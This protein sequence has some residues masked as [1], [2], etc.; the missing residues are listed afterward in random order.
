MCRGADRWG[1]SPIHPVMSHLHPSTGVEWGELSRP[2]HTHSMMIPLM[3]AL[4]T[5][6]GTPDVAATTA[7]EGRLGVWES[8]RAL[9]WHDVSASTCHCTPKCL[10]LDQCFASHGS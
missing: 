2:A 7:T 8:L 3:T 9:G 4:M 6:H 5:I 10:G 1:R